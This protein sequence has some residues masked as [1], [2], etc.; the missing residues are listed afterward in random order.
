VLSC[1]AP[2]RPWRTAAGEEADSVIEAG[3]TLL[4]IEVAAT[5][6]SRRRT[7]GGCRTMDAECRHRRRPKPRW[8]PLPS[9]V[10]PGPGRP[11]APPPRSAAAAM[12]PSW[13]PWPTWSGVLDTG[14]TERS[15]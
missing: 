4:P 9:G 15:W 1:S 10:S 14:G 11:P 13:S 3:H 2:Q 7:S 8:P 6:R 5:R 12:T